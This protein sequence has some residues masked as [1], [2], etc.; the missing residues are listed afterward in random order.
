[1]IGGLLQLATVGKADAPL[2]NKPELFHF[3]QNHKK[4][5]NFSIDQNTKN[6]GTKK[7]DS[8][9]EFNIDKNSDLLKDFYFKV[10]IPYFEIAKTQN[11]KTEIFNRY[12][13]DKVY[14]NILNSKSYIFNISND[15]YIVFP[16][17]LMNVVNTN[18]YNNL[19][20]NFLIEISSD[21][22][23]KYYDYNS[24]VYN[25]K[26][27]E[28]NHNPIIKFLTNKESLWFNMIF[29]LSKNPNINTNLMDLKNFYR[30]ISTKIENRLL[31][32]YHYHN[33]TNN[34]YK[35][36]QINSLDETNYFDQKYT[37][38]IY[39]YVIIKN[40]DFIL[41]DY[42]INN[43]LDIDKTI[44]YLNNELSNDDNQT[45]LLNSVIFPAN[46]LYFILKMKY[47]STYSNYFSFY[48]RYIVSESNQ[49][50][51]KGLGDGVHS[52]LVWD[53][54]FNK[55]IELSFNNQSKDELKLYQYEYFKENKF[56]TLVNIENIWKNLSL[57]TNDN[58][59]VPN[60]YSI[61]YTI[62]FR[63]KNYSNFD[64][65]NWNDYLIQTGQ[66][67][68]F[69]NINT[70]I[71]Q[72][73]L[74]TLSTI[75][76]EY[77]NTLDFSLVFTHFVYVLTQEFDKLKLIESLP[78]INKQNLQFFYWCR[79]KIAN[80]IFIRY[81]RIQYKKFHPTFANISDSTELINFYYTYIPN[82][83][84]S[85]DQI[86]NNFY[87]IFFNNTFIALTGSQSHISSEFQTITKLD[88]ISLTEYNNNTISNISS[89]FIIDVSVD[90]Y[91]YILIDGLYY[92]QLSENIDFYPNDNCESKIYYND[93]YYD[94]TKYFIY[95]GLL[96][97][98]TDIDTI[99]G[100]FSIE[101]NLNMPI[102]KY[103]FDYS[104]L[105]LSNTDLDFKPDKITFLSNKYIDTDIFSFNFQTLT[106]AYLSPISI[107]NK[108][109]EDTNYTYTFTLNENS[110]FN[111]DLFN[112]TLISDYTVSLIDI[113]LFTTVEIT[114]TLYNNIN[115]LALQDTS[116]NLTISS[117]NNYYIV[118]NDKKYPITLI[119]SG[120]TNLYIITNLDITSDL[121]NYP[122]N[123]YYLE[124]Q[125]PHLTEN[126]FSFNTTNVTVSSVDIS[127][128][129]F[130]IISADLSANDLSGEVVINSEI[131]HTNFIYQ[132]DSSVLLDASELNINNYAISDLSSA[133]FYKE[134]EVNFTTSVSLPLTSNKVFN[135][136][137]IKT[138]E[139]SNIDVGII[140][141][142]M[143][144]SNTNFDYEQDK[145]QYQLVTNNDSSFKI[146]NSVLSEYKINGTINL[147]NTST[148]YELNDNKIPFNINFTDIK[149]D[150]IKYS[151][152]LSISDLQ[153]DN[154][155][156][157]TKKKIVIPVSTNDFYNENNIYLK[158]KTNSDFNETDTYEI[159]D[160]DILN[161]SFNNIQKIELIKNINTYYLADFLCSIITI[162]NYDYV[163]FKITQNKENYK[164]FISTNNSFYIYSQ[165]QV[166]ALQY[167]IISDNIVRLKILDVYESF[168]KN[169]PLTLTL[170]IYINSYLPNLLNYTSFYLN[171]AVNRVSDLMDYFIQTPMII[172]LD[173]NTTKDGSIILNNLP[174]NL[175][176][177]TRI[178]YLKLDNNYLHLMDKINSNQLIRYNN[179]LISSSFDN[180]IY[181]SKIYSKTYILTKID[182]IIT[183][184]LSTNNLLEIIN[185]ISLT[186]YYIDSFFDDI[187]NAFSNGTFGNTSKKIYENFTNNN[188]V[189]LSNSTKRINSFSGNDFNLYSNL[190]LD[191]YKGN[192]A[193][194][195]Y[196]TLYGSG[197]QLFLTNYNFMDISVLLNSSM[198]NIL[199]NYNKEL[200]NQI[201]YIENNLTWLSLS[202]RQFDQSFNE[203][204]DYQ[205]EIN[206]YLYNSSNKFKYELEQETD[207]EN[208]TLSTLYYD[209]NYDKLTLTKTSNSTGQLSCD[210][211]EI[212]NG[213]PIQESSI[214]E[215][216]DNFASNNDIIKNQFNFIGPVL[217]ENTDSP[218]IK[219]NF[220]DLNLNNNKNYFFIDDNKNAFT[221]SYDQKINQKEQKIYVDSKYG[222][223]NN[224][225]NFEIITNE[226]F[227]YD[228][229]HNLQLTDTSGNNYK[230]ALID[231]ELCVIS[232]ES[233]NVNLQIISKHKLK[234]THKSI[235]FGVPFN[236][237]NEKIIF[238]NNLYNNI[239]W[240]LSNND[241]SG[242]NSIKHYNYEIY[243]PSNIQS[244]INYFTFDSGI[245]D[246]YS[247]NI[248]NLG[249]NQLF[250]QLNIQNIN[251]E[252]TSNYNITT[253][254]IYSYL[255]NDITN[256]NYP[257]FCDN[258]ILKYYNISSSTKTKLENPETI[259]YFNDSICKFKDFFLTSQD[260]S[261]ITNLSYYDGNI[262]ESY[263]NTD[264]NLDISNNKIFFK[265]NNEQLLFEQN[266]LVNN[267]FNYQN[268][269]YRINDFINSYDISGIEST[270]TSINLLDGRVFNRNNEYYT[271][272]SVLYPGQVNLNPLLETLNAP[273]HNDDITYYQMN[274]YNN[275]LDL[276]KLNYQDINFMFDTF[277][278]PINIYNYESPTNTTPYNI[279]QYQI[280]KNIDSS[281]NLLTS[282]DSTIPILESSLDIN[283]KLINDFSFYIGFNVNLETSYTSI[284]NLRFHNIN[285]LI[286]SLKFLSINENI[287][288][289]ELS[290][291]K[292]KIT[293]PKNTKLSP[294]CFYKNSINVKYI[295]EG[296]ELN[297]DIIFNYIVDSS[298]DKKIQVAYTTEL[299]FVDLQEPLVFEGD[300]NSDTFIKCIS[301]SNTLNFKYSSNNKFSIYTENGIQFAKPNLEF[302]IEDTN[303]F[304]NKLNFMEMTL[305]DPS[306]NYEFI[307]TKIK[308]NE[309]NVNSKYCSNWEMI[310]CGIIYKDR[311]YVNDN[312]KNLF[313]LIENFI[314]Y[315]ND[316]YYFLEKSKTYG[317]YIFFTING[318]SNDSNIVQNNILSNIDFYGRETP[319]FINIKPY[320]CYKMNEPFYIVYDKKN[321]LY[322]KFGTFKFGEI[323]QLKN[324]KIMI[325]DYDL[326]YNQYNFK[327][328][329]R[330]NKEIIIGDSY[331]SLGILS[332]FSKRNELI[333]LKNQIPN[334]LISKN[335]FSLGDFIINDKGIK[336]F[337]SKNDYVS[338]LSNLIN[339]GFETDGID[340]VI[341][342]INNSF[343]YFGNNLKAGDIIIKHTS[344]Y[345]NEPDAYLTI[346][347]ILSHIIIF[348]TKS[349]SSVASLLPNYDNK[350]IFY[351]PYQPFIKKSIQ[352]IC[353]KVS[354]DDKFNGSIRYNN[355]L[356]LINQNQIDT[357]FKN[358]DNTISTGNDFSAF[359]LENN[360][361]YTF[362][363]NNKG[364]LGSGDITDKYKPT[365]VTNTD[366]SGIKSVSCGYEHTLALTIDEKVFAFGEN[367]NGQLGINSYNDKITPTYSQDI[368]G[369]HINNIVSISSGHSFSLLLSKFG[370]V[371]S[372]GD[373][374][375]GQLGNNNGN[376]KQNNFAELYSDVSG[377]NGYNASAIATG[378]YHTLVLLDSGK[379][380]SCGKNN[381][382]QLGLGNTINMSKLTFISLDYLADSIYAGGNNSAILLKS[383][384]I[385]VF[386]DNQYG[387]LGINSI[388]L[389]KS[390]PY[391][392]NFTNNSYDSSN[393]IN[394][395]FGEK[396]SSMLLNSGKVYNFG[397]N[398][399]GQLGI[400]NTIGLSD[401]SGQLI[402]S[403]GYVSTNCV[404]SSIGYNHGLFLLT[405]GNVLTTGSN[406]YGC[407]G[408]D[409]SN[410]E[411][412]TTAK[413]IWNT[414]SATYLQYDV[415]KVQIPNENN[416]INGIYDIIKFTDPYST[417]SKLD[418]TIYPYTIINLNNFNFYKSN[419]IYIQ[420]SYTNLSS[421]IGQSDLSFNELTKFYV[422][423]NDI[424]YYPLYIQTSSNRSLWLPNE[425]FYSLEGYS[426]N[427]YYDNSFTNST[428]IPDNEYK[429]IH[430][431][432]YLTDTN[433]ILHYPLYIDK[434][435]ISSSKIN[436]NNTNISFDGEIKDLS[437]KKYITFTQNYNHSISKLNIGYNSQVLVNGYYFNFINIKS[438][439]KFDVS[440][441]YS[442]FVTN[443]KQLSADNSQVTITIPSNPTSDLN[444]RKSQISYSVNNHLVTIDKNQIHFDY[445]KYIGDTS[446][447]IYCYYTD[448]S[449][450]QVK[451]VNMR[452]TDT[453]ILRTNTEF[454]NFYYDTSGSGQFYLENYI[455]ILLVFDNSGIET[456]NNISSTYYDFKYTKKPN[457]LSTNEPIVIEEIQYNGN[458]IIHFD[459]LIYSDGLCKITNNIG[460][461]NST[462]LINMINPVRINNKIVQFIK[463]Q[464]TKHI[465]LTSKKDNKINNFQSIQEFIQ[466]PIKTKGSPIKQSDGWL[467]KIV[468]KYILLISKYD[469]YTEI[470]ENLSNPILYY[471]NSFNKLELIKISNSFYIKFKFLPNTN[472]D[473]L[474]L[475]NTNYIKT[476]EPSYDTFKINN[477]PTNTLLTSNLNKSWSAENK[478]IKI[479]VQITA[480]NGGNYFILD[481]YSLSN[482]FENSSVINQ[483]L[484][485]INKGINNSNYTEI[486]LET[487]PS[488]Y[489]NT[490][491][492][493]NEYTKSNKIAPIKHEPFSSVKSIIN[494]TTDKLKYIDNFH[495]PFILNRSKP[496]INWTSIT[497][498][499]NTYYK[500][501]SQIKNQDIMID[502]NQNITYIDN[503]NSVL[504]FEEFNGS[505]LIEKIISLSNNNFSKYYELVNIRN[506]E[507]L[508]F[509]YLENNIQYIHFWQDPIS[510][511][512]SYLELIHNDYR[513]IQNCL[514]KLT[515]NILDTNIFTSISGHLSRNIYL[516][517]QYDL[518]FDSINQTLT[519]SRVKNKVITA[520]NDLVSMNSTIKI[521]SYYGVNSEILFIDLT[522][523]Q[524]EYKSF[525]SRNLNSNN[526]NKEYQ[527]LTLEKILI[528]TQWEFINNNFGF[529]ND[530]NDTLEINYNLDSLL[531]YTGI[532]IDKF[533]NKK[534]FGLDSYNKILIPNDLVDNEILYNTKLINSEVLEDYTLD[535]SNIF[536]Y[537]VLGNSK[538]VFEPN[539]EYKLDILDG[540]MIFNDDYIINPEY[541]SNSVRFFSNRDYTNVKNITVDLINDINIT[542]IQKIGTLYKDIILNTNLP[543]TNINFYNNN[544]LI[545][546]DKIIIDNSS[547]RFDLISNDK[548]TDNNYLIIKNKIGII[549]QNIVDDKNYLTFTKQYNELSE[550]VEESNVYIED[551]SISYL[552]NKDDN[553]YYINTTSLLN[554]HIDY[555]IFGYQK[556][557]I[558]R[559]RTD[560]IAYK[561]IL[562]EDLKVP[563]Y[564][565]DKSLPINYTIDNITDVSEIKIINNNEIMVYNTDDTISTIVVT[566]NNYNGSDKFIFNDNSQNI[567][568]FNIGVK[569]KFDQ[570]HYS[571]LNH[572]L[573]ISQYYNTF[574]DYQ[575]ETFGEPGNIGSHVIF[576]PL[577][578]ESVYIY[579][580]ISSSYDIGSLYMPLQIQKNT[581]ENITY[582][583]IGK[584]N[585]QTFDNSNSFI[586]DY[587][588]DT[589]DNTLITTQN[590]QVIYGVKIIKINNINQ[591]V[592]YDLSTNLSIDILLLYKGIQYKFD[593]SDY[594]NTN[595]LLR[596][597]NSSTSLY[598]TDTTVY[599]QPGIED[600]YILFTPTNIGNY[601]IFCSNHG[602]ETGASYNPVIIQS[603]LLNSK[604]LSHK[605]KIDR[606]D[607]LQISTLD[608]TNTKYFVEVNNLIKFLDNSII[609][610][611]KITNNTIESEIPVVI[612]DNKIT[613]KISKGGLLL[614]SSNIINSSILNN[615]KFNIINSIDITNYTVVS[616]S[617]NKL[618]FI[619]DNDLTFNTNE[620]FKYS[621]AF[622]SNTFYDISNIDFSGN[623]VNI[624][625]T[626]II[627]FLNSSD[628]EQA[629]LIMSSSN[630]SNFS[631]KQDYSKEIPI[632]DLS[633]NKTSQIT[634][635]NDYLF[636]DENEQQDISIQL[637]DLSGTEC[638]NYIYKFY[639][640]YNI[641]VNSTTKFYYKQS[642]IEFEIKFLG[643]IQDYFYF[644]SI[645]HLNIND[646]YQTFTFFNNNY[647]L[648]VIKNGNQIDF[649]TNTYIKG[650]ITDVINR[651]TINVITESFTSDLSNLL[652]PSINNKTK[653]YL[654][655]VIN[656]LKI[657][658]M[659]NISYTFPNE[660]NYSRFITTTEN[661]ITTNEEIIW[662]PDIIYNFYKYIEFY[663]NDQLI[664]KHDSDSLKIYMEL[665]KD[666]IIHN[667][668][669]KTTKSYQIFIPTCFWF[670]QNSSN[671]LPLIAMDESTLTV[672]INF[673]KFSELIN[674]DINNIT[675]K[676]PTKFNLRLITDNII[677][678]NNERRNFARFNHE[679]V[680]ERNVIYGNK[681][682]LKYINQHTPTNISLQLKGLVKDI[683]FL[684]KSQKTNKSYILN[685][686][687]EYT[688]DSVNQEYYDIKQLYDTFVKNNRTFSATIPT[689][690]LSKFILIDSNLELILS[691]SELVNKIKN[692]KILSKFDIDFILYLY[693][694]QLK[695]IDNN[696][697]NSTESFKSYLKFTKIKYYFNNV[698][699][700]EIITQ[701]IEPVKSIQLNGNGTS[702][703]SNKHN[704]YYNYV[705][706]YEKFKTTPDDGTFSY[707]FALEPT[708]SQ[709]SGHL[710]FNILENS[711]IDVQFDELTTNEHLKL[712]TI[713]REIQILRI[714]G[715]T[716]SLSWI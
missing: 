146:V 682:S 228:F 235:I 652:I 192:D 237:S 513:I 340:I 561:M 341:Y 241:L 202:D 121:L 70:N 54:Y 386:G 390:I 373:N 616:T 539:V 111:T 144:L 613:N 653:L 179:N 151:Y 22:Y 21:E 4:Y 495:L 424:Y 200:S 164:K 221:L 602:Y 218:T 79:N 564:E 450:P 571:N 53:N 155:I 475:R 40:N 275:L 448:N 493:W 644:S 158:I 394:F 189:T 708:T 637:L 520:I 598:E 7:F 647:T 406:N 609:K 669:T 459:Q 311:I 129:K 381:Y 12:E 611:I 709:P 50:S 593:L 309:T 297:N 149:F 170:K 317:N 239:S 306:S 230:F 463:P 182:E 321:R 411:L 507:L 666:F 624:D 686:S 439:L 407:S 476:I 46:F 131:F 320:I 1:M 94:I 96:T 203:F 498:D 345:E 325:L 14:L 327:P 75:F 648:S 447:N 697:K 416:Y 19:L 559:K 651:K 431:S 398:I 147:S 288:I 597:S 107:N 134:F 281:N 572:P 337:K 404:L 366:L 100:S 226:I 329:N 49:N 586:P 617:E 585:I 629:N 383:G 334:N 103:Y 266:L 711:S 242:I 252:I 405:N 257:I 72:Y 365:L 633:Y 517:L 330:F 660:L 596:F 214:E 106:N 267:F 706:P 367:E 277:I 45:M 541:S 657:K 545:H 339:F 650:T 608:Y 526:F 58:F 318:L 76:T 263:I 30:W 183:T 488:E 213:Y 506:T 477:P 24:T 195:N 163:E 374:T 566:V 212:N 201:K 300:R 298:Y 592:F 543:T 44:N 614:E 413:L 161:K 641:Q 32:D 197:K 67:G 639:Y 460:D 219:N 159:P 217:I 642:T 73:P 384:K 615:Y 449:Q 627:N 466:V 319:I 524:N 562:E 646:I 436:N 705:V 576:T 355:N 316:E 486:E 544:E 77:G 701:Q 85:L 551:N 148:I 703:F 395:S 418:N 15:K 525:I 479:P 39:K 180:D 655:N 350:Y 385:L 698:Y 427:L 166:Y 156:K 284:G 83:I 671:Y 169:I 93:L 437:G 587:T 618:N 452:N 122:I 206:K 47:D 643:I 522:N 471:S 376:N 696:N 178:N 458:K 417:F 120:R 605:Y 357:K 171:D 456:I 612:A 500:S 136:S 567:P 56:K 268:K 438:D 694:D 680:I 26:I 356:K 276:N 540:D 683:F 377:Y 314:I 68:Y 301:S 534:Q 271:Y 187:L 579:D 160:L 294:K 556:L 707:S 658:S 371:F 138:I 63:Y 509:K 249:Y 313:N 505:Q 444:S 550:L 360:Q 211:N 362:G 483:N 123:S 662:N 233:N 654:H 403:S 433:N 105:T 324:C 260:P 469:T 689:S 510:R 262:E 280:Y 676:L 663:I 91:S 603:K 137:I 402:D 626:S 461:N 208:Y 442:Y 69:T 102:N 699:K 607:P 429:S 41:G 43:D 472:I 713:I 48:Q 238:D 716:A 549:S 109:T 101:V 34:N 620:Y 570:S 530:F 128:N 628:L 440:G 299:N 225:T 28:D 606:D 342:K 691:N 322:A 231:T 11:T 359:V 87:Q 153:N 308:F 286:T 673:N 446:D 130:K 445:D 250:I 78:S 638:G 516:D 27:K 328:I 610:F 125:V 636:Q 64:T 514:V 90:N 352:L 670:S 16:E 621:I 529:N 503:S 584:N 426:N 387:Q 487:L 443:S 245:I 278:K 349:N 142:N 451:L 490:E 246:I 369:N 554:Q 216:V 632:I 51:V 410:N 289:N 485:I 253:K 453:N 315:L 515:E 693:Y 594:S 181:D 254:N 580:E 368:S 285:N 10:E 133:I 232:P 175:N 428:T 432:F 569:Y 265:N 5:T 535:S 563:I 635:K 630:S 568:E 29:D 687:N 344:E 273:R 492:I 124:K 35:F 491:Y 6:F 140:P 295:K 323:I 119:D 704:S 565:L 190:V 496:W 162:D 199:L 389:Y 234:N 310:D 430:Q 227:I 115:S 88:Q 631:F 141:L 150:F 668:P 204:T 591:F 38:D 332:N 236:D 391:D 82:Q 678:D 270:Q 465:K 247:T 714:I 205:H 502:N 464:I 474:Y 423:Y 388:N 695:Y 434:K 248:F 590:N 272:K 412:N 99:T 36:F 174:V 37:N 558:E 71:T 548:L 98:Y 484:K 508:I 501:L 382:G 684:F 307:N 290:K 512:N 370:K 243:D 468:S 258:G 145:F 224:E 84:L 400:G 104:P 81:Q 304:T 478:K 296:T 420:D 343:Y 168:D 303:R 504:L 167:P 575:T 462:Y 86:K 372:T 409:F 537:K 497:F 269:Y 546:K 220:L 489:T 80:M 346:K 113:S 700:N 560:Y 89:N 354:S 97:F 523:I 435:L 117:T 139:D 176:K 287:I 482:I 293:I 573:N 557:D 702:L 499:N 152:F 527:V 20:G 685:S 52:D 60:I 196:T 401:I 552:I 361:L 118:Y 421:A 65:I 42:Y 312:I 480:G 581:V 511:I 283:N 375:Y 555:N 692:D 92:V 547:I 244:N 622:D 223:L 481:N 674:N 625:L 393:C 457:L 583:S 533:G 519:I 623:I 578:N 229:S 659:S 335:D 191:F 261:G 112:S 338:N 414:N 18:E 31:Y 326:Q 379:V 279:L 173:P 397:G 33:S 494:Y 194:L 690:N 521:E 574:I 681:Y 305:S 380:L 600:S 470:P 408:L 157:Y 333:N 274:G 619:I 664:D 518:I 454:Y 589:L 582:N 143:D 215:I 422:K 715:G 185:T 419:D 74:Q 95:N 132:N 61:I 9:F 577:V 378:N 348:D 172:F 528:E 256:I 62:A 184:T 667:K 645:N 536:Q 595:Y 455:P 599:G 553:L 55:F 165:G 177:V 209:N 347:S 351:K 127:D 186:N 3:K 542:N 331:Y 604:I 59:N 688:R 675:S 188:L 649:L 207:F 634:L 302:I 110:Q 8:N 2:I 677:L 114:T 531:N 425:N 467:L 66:I 259:I 108:T 712:K 198:L 291:D 473:K 126:S 353:N 57:K 415:S 255:D 25:Y 392:S 661:S 17:Y 336:I 193:G 251:H 399:N 116:G 363:K 679:Y 672:K 222:E 640:P 710:N 588:T 264:V 441:N 240:T 135:W 154:T 23:K 538:V 358:C 656:E 665:Y 601:Y 282:L 364:Q 396:S 532:K 210:N 292:I 13:S